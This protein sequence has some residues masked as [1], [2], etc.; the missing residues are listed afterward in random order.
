MGVPEGMGS[1]GDSALVGARQK[2]VEFTEKRQSHVLLS[3]RGVWGSSRRML[4][5]GVSGMVTVAEDEAG[6]RDTHYLPHR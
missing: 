4:E 3:L 6:G 5:G 1:V 2:E